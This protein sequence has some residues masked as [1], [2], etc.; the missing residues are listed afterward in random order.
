MSKL[1]IHRLKEGLSLARAYQII[2]DDENVGKIYY[3]GTQ[4]IE[5]AP[6]KH[7]LKLKLD[8][9]YSETFHFEVQEGGVKHL[10]VCLNPLYD[11]I[12]FIAFSIVG[13]FGFFSYLNLFD[14]KNTFLFITCTALLGSLYPNTIG[15]N[16]YFK[17]AES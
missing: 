12:Y 14:N 13:M 16:K 1:V 17:I 11:K 9:C 4:E 7:K 5:L 8:W 3:K 6:G 15:R 2:L 10:E